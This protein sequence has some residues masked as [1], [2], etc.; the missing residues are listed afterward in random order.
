MD[1]KKARAGEFEHISDILRNL[2]DSLVSGP[3]ADLISIEQVWNGV[4]GEETAMNT[5][6]ES[7]KQGLL[8][9]NVSAPAWIQ[10][11][12]FLKQNII[13]DINRAVGKTLVKDIKFKVGAIDP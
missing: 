12:R 9:V 1:Q 13:D 7:L 5:S 10:H 4:L 8:V 6:P 3:R 11:L 2:I